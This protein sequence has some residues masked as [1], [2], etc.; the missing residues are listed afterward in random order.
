MRRLIPVFLLAFALPAFAADA[1]APPLWSQLSLNTCGVDSFAAAHPTGDGRGVV[2]AILDCGVELNA[3]G[4]ETTSDGKPKV[5]DV[6]D[7]TGEGDL[8][9]T[10]AEPGADATHVV[11]RDDADRPVT[12]A[13]PA[14]SNRVGDAWYYVWFDEANYKGASLEDFDDD[15]KSETRIPILLTPVQDGADV[16][17]T[18]A[19]DRN[20]NRDFADEQWMTDFWRKRDF[21]YLNRNRPEAERRQITLA[22]NFYPEEHR[23]SLFCDDGG[24]GTHV[25]GIATGN[26][27]NGQASFDG[28]APGAQIIALKIGDNR[29]AGGST[30]PGSKIEAFRYAARYAREHNVP[31]VCNLS[32]GINSEREGKSSIDREIEKLLEDNPLLTICLSAGNEGPGLSTI[33]TPAACPSAISVAAMLPVETARDGHGRPMPDHAIATFSSRGPEALKPDVLTPGYDTSS[34]TL[35]NREG[36]F[37]QGTSMASPYATGL[38]ARLIGTYMHE[39]PGQQPTHDSVKRALMGGSSPLAGYTSLDYGAGIPNLTTAYAALE[40]LVP[41]QRAD[42][43]SAITVS[44]PSPMADGS[45]EVAVWRSLTLPREP[46]VFT[47]TPHFPAV[48]DT[49]TL[50]SFTRRYTLTSLTPWATPVEESVYLRVN[51]PAQV[52]VRY[53]T[54]TLHQPGFY[55]ADIAVRAEG[56]PANAAPNTILRSVVIV[57]EQFSLADN[58]KVTWANQQTGPSWRMDRKFLYVPPYASAIN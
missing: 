1:P 43:P 52:H 18:C 15:G 17:W 28:V 34:V 5:I 54:S 53:D 11:I 8:T 55:I 9:Y 16:A 22:V 36:D 27:I 4:L 32:Y 33:G 49:L 12:C 37:W 23:L 7:F 56:S 3:H 45:P 24:H 25:S 57:P 41:L 38:C 6:R 31:V 40:A 13:V 50:D 58:Y 2:V 44:T 42:D 20:Q 29:L 35:W 46:Q 10:R 19:F 39:H 48:T 26:D 14:L 30:T 47:L 21:I 51:Q